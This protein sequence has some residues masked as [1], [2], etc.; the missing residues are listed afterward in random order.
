[1][2]LG[3]IGLLAMNANSVFATTKEVEQKHP[4]LVHLQS[5]N[6]QC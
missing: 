6:T 4:V 2:A 5:I 1:M 3:I